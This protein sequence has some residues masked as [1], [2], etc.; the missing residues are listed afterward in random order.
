MYSGENTSLFPFVLIP[1][2]L[3]SR[4]NGDHRFQAAA[5]GADGNEEPF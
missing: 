5:F 3:D 1:D 4:Y 2:T